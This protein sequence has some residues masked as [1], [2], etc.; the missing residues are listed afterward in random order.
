MP[1]RSYAY[2]RHINS[3]TVIDELEGQ[4]GKGSTMPARECAERLDAFRQ[5]ALVVAGRFRLRE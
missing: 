5:F 1:L 2:K 4:F 3:R